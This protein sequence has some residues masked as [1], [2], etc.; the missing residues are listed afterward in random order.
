MPMRLQ[1]TF[2]ILFS[3]LALAAM[4][5]AAQA[6]G[7]HHPFAVGA[8]E[9][10]VGSAP[11]L[12]AW[13]IEQ[14]SRFSLGLVGAVRAIKESPYAFWGLASLSFLYGVFHAAG[15][16]HGKAVITSYMISNERALKRG[17][18]IAFLA[19]LLQGIVAIVLVGTAALIFNAT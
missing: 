8:D 10:A 7:I 19:A 17:I 6:Q 15:P 3:G 18:V 12:T 2:L 13:I 9:G 14:E 11:G 1:K 4:I 16:G 5:G